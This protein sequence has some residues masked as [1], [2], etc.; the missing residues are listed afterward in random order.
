MKKAF[1]L[2]LLG[3]LLLAGCSKSDTQ[4]M[5]PG[6][7][8]LDARRRAA[9]ERLQT[10]FKEMDTDKDGKLSDAEKT[11]GFEKYLESDE[12]FRSRVDKDKDGKI[13][14]KEHDHSL[15]MFLMFKP[16]SKRARRGATPAPTE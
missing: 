11:A 12:A 3:M 6:E 5:D 7:V 14:A 10:R 16:V 2:A 8:P 9:R 1:N 15:K 4:P 13:S